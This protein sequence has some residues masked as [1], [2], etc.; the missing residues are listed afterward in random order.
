MIS[1]YPEYDQIVNVVIKHCHTW[2]FRT[3]IKLKYV[4]ETDLNWR[5]PEDNAELSYNWD[6]IYWEPIK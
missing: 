2:D 1:E 4:N 3:D 6:V 5:F